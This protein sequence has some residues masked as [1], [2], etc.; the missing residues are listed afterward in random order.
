M[1]SQQPQFQQQLAQTILP[2]QQMAFA[3]PMLG[4]VTYP[5]QTMLAPMTQMTGM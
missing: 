5:G 4:Q 1:V 2:Q 3:S